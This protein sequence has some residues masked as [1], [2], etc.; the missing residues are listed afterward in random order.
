MA[1]RY[2]LRGKLEV[3]VRAPT[4][5]RQVHRSGRGRAERVQVAPSGGSS[6]RRLVVVLLV[7]RSCVHARRLWRWRR[8]RPRR[9]PRPQPPAAPPPPP[10][11][12][13]E[14]PDPGP[15]ER[16][17]RTRSRPSRPGTSVPESRRENDSRQ[18]AHAVILF[19]DGAQKRH[20]RHARAR[21]N[22]VMKDN[23]GLV[24][25]FI[26]DLGK[27]ASVEQGRHDRGR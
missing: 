12:E 17:R 5:L 11:A 3:T 21:S 27:Y 9:P 13:E 23:R 14:A 7:A 19:V 2:P 26:Y 6:M 16:R 10:P 15:L 18:A 25:L 4:C 24:D 20:E 8:E 1:D 22:A